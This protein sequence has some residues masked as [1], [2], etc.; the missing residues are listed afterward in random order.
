MYTGGPPGSSTGVARK[1]AGSAA[2]TVRGRAQKSER[3]SV[4]MQHLEGKRHTLC[5]GSAVR[6]T[7]LLLWFLA[8]C[9]VPVS[10]GEEATDGPP[11]DAAVPPRDAGPPLPDAWMAPAPDLPRPTIVPDLSRPA[12]HG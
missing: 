1:A 8:G 2:A 11:A 12:G 10:G 6:N 7:A 4:R 9:A 5:Y 3:T